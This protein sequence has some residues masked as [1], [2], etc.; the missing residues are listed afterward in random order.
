MFSGLLFAA[1]CLSSNNAEAQ[2][3]TLCDSN[4]CR[5]VD[6]RNP[7]PRQDDRTQEPALKFEGYR[8]EPLEE[9]ERRAEDQDI[10]AAYKLGLVLSKGLVAVEED[11]DKAIYY[12]SLAAE[13]GHIGA[14][15]AAAETI[16]REY[17]APPPPPPLPEPEPATAAE[18]E[19]PRAEPE[20]VIHYAPAPAGAVRTRT[21]VEAP[22]P[23]VEEEPIQPAP[24]LAGAPG[25]DED[26]PSPE[27]DTTETPAA[28]PEPELDPQEAQLAAKYLYQASSA[29]F[30]PAKVM[31]GEV[32]Y[33]GDLLGRDVDY[34]AE[35]FAEAADADNADA[36]YYIGQMHFR[37]TGR[38]Q[39]GFKAIDW[40][41]KAAK[42]GSVLAQRALGQIYYSGYEN[43]RQDKNEASRWLTAAAQNGDAN[44]ARVLEIKDSGGY[45]PKSK[46]MMSLLPAGDIVR[47]SSAAMRGI[48]ESQARLARG[49]PMQPITISWDE[50]ETGSNSQNPNRSGQST[51]TPLPV[52]APGQELCWVVGHLGRHRGD[53]VRDEETLCE[54]DAGIS[55]L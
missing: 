1:I 53:E 3:R 36:Q 48:Q 31:L 18:P 50:P 16:L 27:Q 26:E 2:K 8:G 41:R 10:V 9:L 33:R 11:R 17:L 5:T 37:G 15:Y 25:T 51:I 38:S 24:D 49:E 45:V 21:R 55:N 22:E 4:G 43:L 47:A 40:T 35:L 29:G 28:P 13:N 46:V 6:P 12:L 14:A 20:R 19:K 30:I 39:N 42:N 34:A 23:V 44:S 7:Q 54:G 52:S 32:L